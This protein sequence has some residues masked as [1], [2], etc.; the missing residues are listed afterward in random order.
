MWLVIVLQRL[1]S[2]IFNWL[3][4]PDFLSQSAIPGYFP[5]SFMISGALFLIAPEITS[6]D[7]HFRR[8]WALLVAIAIGCL[9]A[10]VF[11]G[12]SISSG[13]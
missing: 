1:Y 3:G 13:G 4:Q 7:L 9:T 8:F 6:N 10:G 5:Y 2:G 12:Y 11:I